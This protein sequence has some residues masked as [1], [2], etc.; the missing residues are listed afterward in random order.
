MPVNTRKTKYE[1]VR[2]FAAIFIILNHVPCSENAQLVNILARRLFFLGGKFGVN[3]FVILGAWFLADS[4]EFK[5][6]RIFRIVE[7]SIFYSIVLDAVCVMAGYRFHL[8][9]F[10]GSFSYWYSFGYVAMLL[11]APYLQRI[12]RS[13]KKMIVI[14]G[15]ALPARWF[16]QREKTEK[17]KA[18][19]HLSPY[20][21][22]KP[23]VGK[24]QD[25]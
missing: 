20:T 4:A 7:K 13:K 21:I 24:R 5:S 11:F 3:L 12:C 19:P 15:G 6:N 23:A 17:S 1:L 18:S 2:V 10:A 8:R 9:A 25:R 22:S 14:T 16:C